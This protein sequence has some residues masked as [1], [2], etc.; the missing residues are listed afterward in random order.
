M[1]ELETG[2]RVKYDTNPKAGLSLCIQMVFP[3]VIQPQ[4]CLKG[5]VS[6]IPCQRPMS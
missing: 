4:A 2:P 3:A 5:M 1:R 6:T